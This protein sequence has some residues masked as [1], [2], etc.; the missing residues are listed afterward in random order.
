MIR[1]IPLVATIIVVAAVALMVWLGL[2][3]LQRAKLHAAQLA[4]YQSAANLPPIAFPTTPV[5]SD[6]LPLYR[7]ATGNCLRVV[8]R[9]TA[10]GENRAEEPGFLII[11]DCATGAEGPGMSVEIGWSKN[12]NAAVKWAGGLV[13]GVIVPDSVARMRLV[14]ATSVPGIEPSAIPRPTVRITPARNKGYAATWFALALA[15]LVIYAIAVRKHL[16]PARRKP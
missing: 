5:R 11:V 10:A 16:A 12:P 15:A 1:R 3:Q 9:R 14:A 7:Y 13:S 8:G 6:A 4:S 2:W